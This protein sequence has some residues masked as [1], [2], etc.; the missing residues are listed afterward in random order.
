MEGATDLM[1]AHVVFEADESL[2]GPMQFPGTHGPV[3]GPLEAVT[4][5]LLNALVAPKDFDETLREYAT[6]AMGA[7]GDWLKGRLGPWWKRPFDRYRLM[8][9]LHELF[10]TTPERE[11]FERMIQSWELEEDVES[12]LK[13]LLL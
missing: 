12:R 3:Y 9:L 4:A 7:R 8:V 1:A 2:S 11:F 5:G 10:Q 13:E 6:L